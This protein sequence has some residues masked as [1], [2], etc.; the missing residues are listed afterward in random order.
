MSSQSQISVCNIA[1]IAAGSRS[2]VNSINPSDGSVAANACATLYTYIFEMLART[3]RWSCLKKQ[4]NATL[5]QA[6]QGTPENPDGTSLPIPQQPWMYAYTYP[7]DCLLMRQVLPPVNTFSSG[8]NQLSVA[9]SVAPCIPGQTQVPYEIATSQDSNGNPIQIILTNQQNAVINYNL[10]NPNPASW[11]SLFTGA[12]VAS[13][14]VYLIPALSL[15]PQLMANQIKLADAAITTAR[16]A[17]GNENPAVQ[18][19][20]PDWMRARQGATGLLTL[21]GRGY[22]AYGVML[23]P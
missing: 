16:G 2:R 23:W 18:D 3:A 17:D 10:N 14:A 9:N 20:I 22:E 12:Y 1:L 19:H 6:A 8:I 15:Q 5:I 11:D 4:I 21:N 13:L 7:A